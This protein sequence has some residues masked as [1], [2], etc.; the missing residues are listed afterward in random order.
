MK[1]V[2]ALLSIAGLLTFMNVNSVSAQGKNAAKDDKAAREHRRQ[3]LNLG[4]LHGRGA[5]RRQR[6]S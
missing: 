6:M 3:K 1:K 5:H 2:I 4:Q